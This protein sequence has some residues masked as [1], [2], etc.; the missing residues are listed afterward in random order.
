MAEVE[1]GLQDRNVTEAAQA[2]DLGVLASG[3]VDDDEV[4]RPGRRKRRLRKHLEQA[5]VED[6]EGAHIAVNR[7]ED[8]GA[9][10]ADGTAPWRF[11]SS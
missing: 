2:L 3:V 5:R 6:A 7:G 8:P 1:R 10:D 9:Q 4:H 11:S